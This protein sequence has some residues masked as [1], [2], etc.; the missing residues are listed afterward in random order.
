MIPL[1]KAYGYSD[2]WQQAGVNVN[3]STCLNYSNQRWW[4]VT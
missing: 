4:S 2:R 3:I 1:I